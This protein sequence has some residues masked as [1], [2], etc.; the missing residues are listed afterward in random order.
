MKTTACGPEL[1]HDTSFPIR[2]RMEALVRLKQKQITD[3]IAALDSVEFRTDTW[4]R[5]NDGGGGQLMVLQDG[6]TFEKGG[7]N[8]SVVHGKLPPQAVNR[9]KADH[10]NL[11]GSEDGLVD[12][13]ACG[14]SLVI[15]PT[16]PHAPT[17]H[18]NYRYFETSDPKTKE[19]TAWWFG[20]GADL[21]PSYLYDEDAKNF[22]LQHKLALDKY[23]TD[24]YPTYK[25]WCDEY[26]YIKHRGETRGVGGIF[27]D[28][29]DSKPADEI[30][31]IIEL[32]FDAFLPAYIPLVEKRMNTPFTEE[33]KQW[34]QI[35]RGRY[36][37][38]NLVL[39]R[40]TQFGLQTP[41]SRVESI[42]MSLPAT[43]SWVYDHHPE[44]GLEE[45]RLLQVLKAPVDWV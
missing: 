17:T 5:G 22:H 39:D 37:E 2:Q 15:H 1:I 33:Q 35:R 36:V 44:P 20:G 3:A 42:L 13:F 25:K 41:G 38:F 12:F 34:Q 14:L 7:V 26:F 18:L 8:I 10:R 6:K 9:M 21:T 4:V 27:F 31:H 32:C 24:L 40:G 11:K 23:D 30:L 45:D 16:N 19:I 29:F 28:D 43:A